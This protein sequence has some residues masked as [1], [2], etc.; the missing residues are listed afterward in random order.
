LRIP[1]RRCFASRLAS[2][3]WFC[4]E[5]P[6]PRL[7]PGRGWGW[8]AEARLAGRAGASP[9]WARTAGET[10]PPTAIVEGRA[11]ERPPGAGPVWL[12]GFAFDPEGGGSATWSSFEPRLA[13]PW[14][15]VSILPA[16]A[17]PASSPSKRGGR[18][19]GGNA[20]AG[21][22]AELGARLTGLRSDGPPCRWLDPHPDLPVRRIRQCPSAGAPSKNRGREGDRPSGGSPPGRWQKVVLGPRG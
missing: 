6:E 18:P 15:E 2:D 12:G 5:Q 17:M 3:R 1:A 16:R 22:P 21:A 13:L 10:G 19:G 8:R 7:R 4:W 14:P 11:R 9:R 20:G